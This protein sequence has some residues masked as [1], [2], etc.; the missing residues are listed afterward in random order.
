MK[1]SPFFSGTIRFFA[2]FKEDNLL[3]KLRNSVLNEAVSFYNMTYL[4]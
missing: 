1:K 4:L 2:Y 3:D